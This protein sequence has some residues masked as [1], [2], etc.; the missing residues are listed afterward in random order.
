MD[1]ALPSSFSGLD[2]SAAPFQ[3]QSQSRC[4]CLPPTLPL[5]APPPPPPLETGGYFWVP[6]PLILATLASGCICGCVHA[7]PVAV[8]QPHPGWTLPP[9]PPPVSY[10]PAPPMPMVVYLCPPAPLPAAPPTT[11]CSIM[12]IVEGGAADEGCKVEPCDKASRRAR[13]AWRKAAIPLR[14]AF[15]AALSVAPPPPLPSSSP[16]PSPFVFGTNTTSLMIRNIPNKFLKARL[17]AILDQHCADENGGLVSP[18]SGVRSEYDFLYVPIDFRTRFNKGYA[19]VNMT[20]AAAAGRLRA[21]LQDHRW[22]AAMSGKVCDVVPAAIQGRDALVAHFSAS[23]FPCRTKT[24]LPVW[25]E[26]PR[27]GVQETKAHV[28]GRLVSHP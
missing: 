24:F 14:K 12:E 26:P 22:D 19:F 18:G 25:F 13:A 2:P 17:M 23:C 9:P 5:L 6:Q 27:D 21:F 4:L 11:R 28:V 15:R 3:P 1:A 20:T 7:V 16:S 8:P 10:H